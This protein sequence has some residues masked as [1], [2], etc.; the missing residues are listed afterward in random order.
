MFFC[1][2]PAF[3]AGIFWT[4][5]AAQKN[6]LFH[7]GLIQHKMHRHPVLGRVGNLSFYQRQQI[8]KHLVRDVVS[9]LV[10]PFT[11]N[12]LF[13]VGDFRNRFTANANHI[14][15]VGDPLKHHHHAGMALQGKADR[16]AADFAG[17]SHIGSRH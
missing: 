2:I 5:K 12:Q 4:G 7:N 6:G 1:F 3:A 11:G 16:I 8:F 13:P 9:L 10:D 15:T 17:F 14:W